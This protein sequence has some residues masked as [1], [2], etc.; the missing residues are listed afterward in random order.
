MIFTASTAS[1]TMATGC[2]LSGILLQKFGCKIT[3]FLLNVGFVIGWVFF[4]FSANLTLILIGRFLTGF[5]IGLLGPTAPIYISEITD[6]SYRGLFLATIGAAL[7]VGIMIPHALGVYLDW[8]IIAAI[9]GVPPFISYV[10]TTFAPE[11]PSWLLRQN[12]I[13][14]A[15]K[16][17]HWFRGYNEEQTR[18][19]RELVQGQNNVASN[20]ENSNSADSTN[21]ANYFLR[22]IKDK[23]FYLPLLILLAYFGTLQLSGTNAVAFYTI[24]ILKKS[25]GNGINEYLATIV[26]DIT[27]IMASILACIVVKKF[28]RRS[29]TIFS[30]IGTAVSLLGLSLYLYLSLTNAQLK[31]M[32]FIPLSLFA[33]YVIFVTIGLNPLAWTLTGELF[34]LR[35]RA[36]GSALVTFFNFAFFFLVVKMSPE[37]F[38]VFKEH[39]VFLIYGS[40]C[41]AGTIILIVYLPETRNKTLQEIENNYFGTEH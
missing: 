12:E 1:L 21:I 34:P 14:E 33:L 26:V 23:S 8:Q 40:L 24:G 9:C 37:M 22:K 19:F 38:E 31:N 7:S 4:T 20:T 32:S 15:E 25:L 30:G 17:F 10:L 28:S 16:A 35:H 39:G 3:F 13:E 27:R 41:L 18:E 11:S 36:L 2:L 6:P 5:S 29:L